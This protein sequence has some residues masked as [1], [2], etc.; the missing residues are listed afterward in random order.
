MKKYKDRWKKCENY[1]EIY[2]KMV[3]KKGFWK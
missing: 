2:I 1:Y 3:L